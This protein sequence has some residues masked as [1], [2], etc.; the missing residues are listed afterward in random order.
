MADAPLWDTVNISVTAL[1]LLEHAYAHRQLA[2]LRELCHVLLRHLQPDDAGDE[3]A[4]A[5]QQRIDAL[6]RDYHKHGVAMR[7]IPV[8]QAPPPVKEHLVPPTG[9][10][11]WKKAKFKA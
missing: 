1:A 7:P 4:W 2:E 8:H 6:R 11:A 5:L 10:T 3:T 9:R